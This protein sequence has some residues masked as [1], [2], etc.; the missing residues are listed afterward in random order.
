MFAEDEITDD[1]R[2]LGVRPGQDLLVH[3]SMRRV[4]PLAAGAATLLAAIRAAGR[5][6]TVVVPTQTTSNSTTSLTFRAATRGMD[7]AE[8]AAFESEMPGFDPLSSPSERMGALA[9]HVRLHPDAVRSTHPQTSFAALGPGAVEL[10][11]THDLDC[12]LGERSPLGALYRSGAGVLLIGVGYEACTALHLAE[13]R[14]P[15]HRRW[16]RCYVRVNGVRE[17]RDFRE[18]PL[19]D[20]DFPEAGV[21]IDHQGFVRRGMIGKAPSRLLD[22]RSTVDFMIDWMDAHRGG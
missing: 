22:L 6:G 3:C 18:L 8:L 10:T 21:L 16:Y 5:D 20:T 7:A 9:E 14:R 19:D 2:A 4:G 15:G 1:L 17:R 11:A 13:Y 12:R